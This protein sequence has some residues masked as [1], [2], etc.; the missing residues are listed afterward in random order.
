MPLHELSRAHHP[1]HLSSHPELDALKALGVE[2]C[3]ER[4][5]PSRREFDLDVMR[6]W[7]PHVSVA[8]VTPDGRFQFRLFGTELAHVYGRD[9]TGCFLEVDANDLWLVVLLHY[10]DGPDG[11]RFC[12]DLSA[13][14]GI[15][16]QPP[17]LPS[18]AN[19]HVPSSWR[20][21]Y[22]ALTCIVRGPGWSP[23]CFDTAAVG[24]AV[25]IT[26]WPSIVIGSAFGP[27]SAPSIDPTP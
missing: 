17:V 18:F 22:S 9:L 20:A 13:R 3:G 12:A 11:R 5:L 7:A 8:V 21:D 15:P 14:S 25:L 26:E 1:R 16:S 2:V 6:R 4:A 10:P 24:H 23:L 19:S 27:L